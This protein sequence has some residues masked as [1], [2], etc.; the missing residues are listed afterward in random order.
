MSRLLIQFSHLFKSFG[1]FSLFDDIS[2]SINQGEIFAL[3]GEN[4]AGKTTLLQLLTGTASPDESRG[5]NPHSF[6]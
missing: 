5:G 3:I 1:P 4:G 6:A 2:L